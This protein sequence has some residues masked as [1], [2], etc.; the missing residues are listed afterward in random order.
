MQGW[1]RGNP[2]TC[3][4]ALLVLGMNLT[5]HTSTIW[6]GLP[7][8]GAVLQTLQ[9]D[10]ICSQVLFILKKLGIGGENEI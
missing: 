7:S 5:A 1:V 9:H 2:F 10:Y 4:V 6:N 3:T 8:S